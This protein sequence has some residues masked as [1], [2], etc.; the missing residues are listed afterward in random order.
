M[1]KLRDPEPYPDFP[2][3]PGEDDLPSDDGEPMETGRH[4]LQMIL[5]VLQLKYHWRGR[6]DRYVA[7]NMFV[8]YSPD[9][10]L[11]EDFKGPDVFVALDVPNRDRKS[12]LVWQEGKGPD[13]VIELL[14]DSTACIDKTTKKQI[15][16][17]K[18]RVPEYFWF[19]PWSGELAGFSLHDGVYQPLASDA[20]GRLHSQRL[21]LTLMRWTGAYQEV[22]ATW[23]R[24]A[25]P[26]GEVLLT[27][28]EAAEQQLQRAELEH[29]RAEQAHTRADQEHTRAE[30]AHEVALQERQHAE[31]AERRAA[32]LEALVARLQAQRDQ[33]DT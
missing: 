31:Q 7:G 32:E 29:T 18:L 23:L 17:D 3:P 11:T 6:N 33:T 19:D 27:S 15:Y 10:V 5:L 26:D 4:W 21:G 22:E 2:W 12:W 1:V 28:D 13:V 25:T 24:W 8:Y 9:Q 20:D 30:Q 14:S 16:Q